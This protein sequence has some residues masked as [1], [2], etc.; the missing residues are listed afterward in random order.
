MLPNNVGGLQGYFYINGGGTFYETVISALRDIT[1]YNGLPKYDVVRDMFAYHR[2]QS[3][4]YKIPD[5]VK[6]KDQHQQP[7]MVP[8]QCF[9]AKS[10]S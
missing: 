6:N 3:E 2:L 5:V 4:V 1:V 8:K 10:L 9:Y 7:T